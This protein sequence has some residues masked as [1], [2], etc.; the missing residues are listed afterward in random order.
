M[1]RAGLEELHRKISGEGNR[2]DISTQLGIV[3]KKR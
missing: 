3:K 1:N 2:M